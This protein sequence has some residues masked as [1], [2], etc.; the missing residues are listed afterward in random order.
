MTTE[1]RSDTQP[2]HGG[3]PTPEAAAAQRSTLM[4]DATFRAAAMNPKSPQWAQLQGLDAAI[5]AAREAEEA[6]QGQPSARAPQ[7]SAEDLQ[8]PPE[9]LLPPPDPK[10]YTFPRAPEGIEVDHAAEA[11]LKQALFAAQVDANFASLAY[12][13]AMNDA[14]RGLSAVELEGARVRTEQALQREW[15]SEYE[16]RISIALEEALRLFSQLPK[17]TTNGMDFNT[18][19][20]ETGLGDSGPVIKQLYMRAKARAK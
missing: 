1:I 4:G 10:G 9:A 16:E 20:L 8:A 6:Q 2:A 11:E 18:F 5:A 7:H 12:T 3:A 14:T 17:S 13:A 19:M 15:G